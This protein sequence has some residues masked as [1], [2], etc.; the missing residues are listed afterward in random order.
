MANCYLH[1]FSRP[2]LRAAAGFDPDWAGSYFVPRAQVKPPIE[3][4]RKV[5]PDVDLWRTAHEDPE[6]SGVEDNKAARMIL[7]LLEWLRE[8]IL[9]NTPYLQTEF[10]EH[11]IW[12]DPLF[13]HPAYATWSSDLLRTADATITDTYVETIH[14]AVPAIGAKLH[15]LAS[16]QSSYQASLLNQLD[17]VLAN[18]RSLELKFQQVFQRP[19]SMTLTPPLAQ[20]YDFYGQAQAV[21]MGIPIQN[22]DAHPQGS[23]PR[24]S[25]SPAILTHTH[26]IPARSLPQTPPTINQSGPQLAFPRQLETVTALLRFWEHGHLNL[27]PGKVLES[28]WGAQWRRNSDREYYSIRKAV[29]DEVYSRAQKQPGRH[30]DDVAKDM[31]KERGRISVY[32]VGK[33]LRALKR[34][35]E[36]LG[37]DG[38][39]GG[40]IDL[41]AGLP[42]A[43]VA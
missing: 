4:M 31:D 36:Q 25:A 5:Y 1:P 20:G 19:W 3:L 30:L 24:G 33:A 27:P 38:S 40:V 43:V 8:V 12:Q 14:K 15:L 26:A 32:Q 29:I 13:R 23:Y 18:Q 34:Q 7:E 16:T 17:K 11:P 37:V 41:G 28:R 22:P 42:I 39:G 6:R 2:A 9:Q 21:T 10:P 35:N